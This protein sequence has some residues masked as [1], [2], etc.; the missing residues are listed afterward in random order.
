MEEGHQRACC[1]A[2][3]NRSA[4]CEFTPFVNEC[5]TGRVH[6]PLARHS[7]V[8][9]RGGSPGSQMGARDFVT[10]LHRV[11]NLE[12]TVREYTGAFALGRYLRAE[13]T[14]PWREAT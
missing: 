8:E 13:L 14:F 5:P 11:V 10:N 1:T 7:N 3:H 9:V 4:W 12:R 2:D 6:G